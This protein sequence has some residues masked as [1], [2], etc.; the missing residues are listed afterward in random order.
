MGQLLL[1]KALAGLLVF[2]CRQIFGAHRTNGGDNRVGRNC[3]IRSCVTAKPDSLFAGMLTAP[4]APLAPL[5]GSP[6]D[7]AVLGRFLTV[8]AERGLE[9]YPEQEEA[10]LELYAGR[11]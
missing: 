4:T 5:A 6:G 1:L 2:D 8:I 10:I 11:N 9:L 3:A 7:D